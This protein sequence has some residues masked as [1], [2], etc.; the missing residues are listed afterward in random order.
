MTLVSLITGIQYS[1]RISLTLLRIVSVSTLKI[2]DQNSKYD[3]AMES[4]FDDKY[5][6]YFIV[7][8]HYPPVEYIWRI[9]LESTVK[10]MIK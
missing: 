4:I 7:N 2:R 8:H 5:N 9:P 10:S 1:T 6:S 3:H